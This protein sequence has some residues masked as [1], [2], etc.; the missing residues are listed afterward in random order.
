MSIRIGRRQFITA[1]GG[2]IAAWP[3]GAIAQVWPQ[4]VVRI[5]VPY[6]PG[7]GTDAFAR[8]MA[9]GLTK[10]A[11]YQ[12]IVENKGGGNTNIGTEDVARATPDGYT[13][14]FGQPALAINRFLFPTL[15]YD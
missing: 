2:A 11:G 10:S 1:F 8:I 12:V 15:G 6:A 14:L 4:R 13:L 9:A 7:G 3:V 5:V